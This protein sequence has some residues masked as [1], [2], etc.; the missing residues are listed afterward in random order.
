MTPLARPWFDLH[1]PVPRAWPP[2]ARCA[3]IA[4]IDA[5]R[6]RDRHGDALHLVAAVLFA[7]LAS[8]DHAPNSIAF[9]ILGG[10]AL[11]RGIVFPALYTPLLR[12]PPL[13]FGAA[14]ATWCL[15]SASWAPP[16]ADSAHHLAGLRAL[17]IPVALWPVVR[18]R[19]ALAWALLAG[20]AIN[21]AAQVAQ[22]AGLLA[23]SA[24]A[25]LRPSGIVALPAVA[26][27][28][29]GI[30]VL[31]SIALLPSAARSARVALACTA[32]V[33]AAG[34][35]LAASRGP[36]LALV[37]TAIL[38]VALL[39]A[40]RHA[41]LARVALG[42]LIAV[43]AAAVAAPFVALEFT[44]YLADAFAT[45][46]PG[47]F[48]SIALRLYWW[49]EALGFWRSAPIAGHGAG[50]F[51][52]LLA[53]RESALEFAR[54]SSVPHAHI[55]QQHPHN[56]LLRALA[57]TGLI[58]ALLLAGTAG[59]VLAAAFARARRDALAAGA[60]ASLVFVGL[61]AMTECPEF[62]T[63]SA[64][65]A[66]IVAAIGALPGARSGSFAGDGNRSH[67]AA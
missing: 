62:M 47:G 57:E 28:S 17:L 30:G 13:W 24:H 40:F 21:A 20:I 5:V 31:L 60:F 67:D 12:W 66:A 59:A 6:A 16:D 41:G 9:A 56:S 58:G 29:G 25:P 48:S 3:A 8:L 36:A 55:L 49:E 34:V 32:L 35:A 4:T 64:S 63:I 45:H 61:A 18:H 7:L 10:V 37:P 33:S 44:R 14:W 46:R 50:S 43:A 42:T 22:R 1:A 54:E 15:A 38:L 23:P 39:V 11:V 19:R 51:A 27:I 53:V 65:Q 26:A 52:P 2:P